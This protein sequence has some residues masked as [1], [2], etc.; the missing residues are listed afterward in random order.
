VVTKEKR[1]NNERNKERKKGK[2][3]ERK[4]TQINNENEGKIMARLLENT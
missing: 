1:R 2:K 4:R 3:K